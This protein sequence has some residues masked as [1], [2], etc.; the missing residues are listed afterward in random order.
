[1]IEK[2]TKLSVL[3]ILHLSLIISSLSG[4]CSKKAALSVSKPSMLFWYAGVLFLMAVYAAVWQQV[5]KRMPLTMAY[6]NKPV[7]LLWGMLWGR[8][9]FGEQ[10]TW[11]MILAAT[12]IS[13][14]I[15]LVVT[16]D[17]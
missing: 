10:I 13:V 1:M 7:S 14:G 2:R 3:L 11:K 8:I 15:G 4:V 6:A 9:L 17:E 12:V 5:L 16:D